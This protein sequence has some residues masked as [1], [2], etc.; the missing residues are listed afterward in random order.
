MSKKS[1]EVA[2]ICN[3]RNPECSGKLNCFYR[4]T[5][6]VKGACVHTTDPKY[7]KNGPKDPKRNK[8]LFDKFAVGD[9]IRYYEKY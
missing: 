7:A 1:Y 8:D 9:V 6:G 4:P 2:Y 3:G 5:N